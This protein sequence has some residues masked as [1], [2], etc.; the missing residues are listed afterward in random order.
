KLLKENERLTG[1]PEERQN[2]E[3]VSYAEL[4]DCPIWPITRSPCAFSDFHFC[5]RAATDCQPVITG[6]RKTRTRIGRNSQ[7]T[8][9]RSESKR[10]RP[11]GTVGGPSAGSIR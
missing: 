2:L 1:P 8:P 11:G 5:N 10:C 4:F 9:G 7:S 6:F 3:R